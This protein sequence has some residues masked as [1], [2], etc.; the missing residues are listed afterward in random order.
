MVSLHAVDTVDH[1]VDELNHT[2]IV[3]AAD[4][5]PRRELSGS[6]SGGRSAALP[7]GSTG[8]REAV[9]AEAARRGPVS[10]RAGR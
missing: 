7:L 1:L 6:V 2:P 5:H 8:D 3:V 9:I 4:R 10:A